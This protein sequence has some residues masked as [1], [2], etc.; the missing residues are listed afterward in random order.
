MQ[1][2]KVI[3]ILKKIEKR[4]QNYNIG[5]NISV[6]ASSIRGTQLYFQF[7]RPSELNNHLRIPMQ[8]VTKDFFLL[9]QR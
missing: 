2:G 4:Y 8:C 9:L 3:F 6:S 1:Q 5:K 7:N